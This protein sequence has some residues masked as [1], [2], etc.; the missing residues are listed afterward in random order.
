MTQLQ[1]L[2][3]KAKEKGL[4]GYSSMCKSD[5]FLLLEGKRIPKR[6]KKN[7]KCKE[8]QTDFPICYD[9]GLKAVMS[10]LVFKDSARR[11]IA[12]DGYLEI[13]ADTEEVIGCEVDYSRQ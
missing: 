9:C 1:E 11:K 7:Q 8:T 3:K 13:D 5:L 12:Y 10:H 2:R 6:L 4:K